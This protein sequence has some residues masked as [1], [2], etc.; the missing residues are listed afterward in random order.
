MDEQVIAILQR[1]SDLPEFLG[2]PL[3]SVNARGNF[4]NTPLHVA[5]VRGDP[6]EVV[7][8]LQSGAQI[9]AK[10]E[11]GFTALHDAVEQGHFEVV[12]VLIAN[13]ADQSIRND[14]G[15]TAYDLLQYLTPEHQSRIGSLLKN[16]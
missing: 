7:S 14:E 13:H 4:G 10:G 15:E 11:H 12:Q 2:L 1:Y 5:S 8:L 6:H 3:S 9:D 16:V